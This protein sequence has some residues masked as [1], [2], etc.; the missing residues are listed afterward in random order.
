[1]LKF[2][3]HAVGYRRPDKSL[4]AAPFE[5]TAEEAQDWCNFVVLRPAWLPDGCQ[6]TSLS[7]R[8]E[9][10]QQPASLHMTIAGDARAFRLK[11]FYLDWW[12][13]TSSDANLTAPGKPFEAAGIVGYEGRD[14]KGRQALC[15]HRYGALLE[16]AILEGQFR[17]EELREFLEKLE[18]QVPEAV[19]EIAAL[20]FSQISYY[21]RKGPGPGPWNYD[22]MTACRWSASR[23]IWKNA[24]E[25]ARTYYPRW[26]PPSYLFD[27]VGTRQE[28][29]SYHW[30]YQL[31]FRH[32]G[33]WTDNLWIRAVGEETQKLLWVAPGLDRRMGVQLKTVALENR[34]VRIGSTSEPY[35]ER[36]AQWIENGVALEV[37][38][39]ASRHVSQQ[40]FS[41]FLDSLAV[42]AEPAK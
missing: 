6:R 27:S 14:Y 29:S 3:E 8:P 20:P 41:H 13:P 12:V 31:L 4:S 39:R 1:M 9:T 5:C 2:W 22:L 18:P 40:D 32:C 42:E 33:N 30:E 37:H 16:L 23:E 34:T 35:G 15:I 10:P 19:L 38:A 36:F 26:L 17:H 11:Q 25:P 24:F 21:A 28:P 7:V